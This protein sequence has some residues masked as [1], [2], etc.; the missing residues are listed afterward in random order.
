MNE[1]MTDEG[2]STAEHLTT[3]ITFVRFL[4]SMNSLMNYEV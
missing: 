2:W 4:S 1:L 3:L